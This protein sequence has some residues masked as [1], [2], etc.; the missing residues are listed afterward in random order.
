MPSYLEDT[1]ENVDQE[2]GHLFRGLL[3]MEVF[4][5]SHSKDAL[6]AR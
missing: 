1:V 6:L 4:N 3:L 2:G 5:S